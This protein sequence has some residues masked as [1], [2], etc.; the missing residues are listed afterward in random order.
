MKGAP[1]VTSGVANVVLTAATRSLP[2]NLQKFLVFFCC[3]F[4]MTAR[5]LGF[6]VGR[7]NQPCIQIAEIFVNKISGVSHQRNPIQRKPNHIFYIVEFFFQTQHLRNHQNTQKNGCISVGVFT[8][9]IK[10]TLLSG[11]FIKIIDTNGLM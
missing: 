5:F 3:V 11:S 7:Q 2:G 6:F 8:V 4:L 10:E 1:D 9:Q